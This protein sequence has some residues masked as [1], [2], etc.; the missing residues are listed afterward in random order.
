MS[1]RL[2]LDLDGYRF[3]ILL[4]E[5]DG[6]WTARVED[7]PG[8]AATGPDRETALARVR[9]AILGHLAADALDP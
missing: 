5:A 6:Q 8:C 3:A 1:E 2:E 9:P 7:L 4:T